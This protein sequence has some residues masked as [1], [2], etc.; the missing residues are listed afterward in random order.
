MRS[1]SARVPP[2]LTAALYMGRFRRRVLVHRRR[3][4]PRRLDPTTHNHPGFPDGVAGTKLLDL[5]REH[6]L[7]Y[8]ARILAGHDQGAVDPGRRLQPGA[9]RP[10]A[11]RRDRSAGLRGRGQRAGPARGRRG[12]PPNPAAHLPDLRRFRGDGSAGRR[13]RPRPAGRARGAV[14]AHLCRPVD[15]DPHRR[16]GRPAR[17]RNAPCWPRPA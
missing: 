17:S 7:R 10:I 1:S 5:Q 14:P 8:G 4:Q 2:G 12:R 16:P 13:D 15:P 3:R 11:A 6:A 9:R